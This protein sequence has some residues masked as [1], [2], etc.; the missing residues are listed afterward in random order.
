MSG[1]GL[2][3]NDPPFVSQPGA[4]T[5]VVM[6]HAFRWNHDRLVDLIGV[7]EKALG[8]ENASNHDPTAKLTRRIDFV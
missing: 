6:L 2:K 4:T 3:Y 5:L 8:C 7:V 1:C